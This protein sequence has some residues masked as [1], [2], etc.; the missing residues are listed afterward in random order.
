MTPCSLGDLFAP[1][2]VPDVA[3]KDITTDSR[4]IR[5]GSL[6]LACAGRRRHGLEFAAQAVA[7][8]A[9]A[10]AWE[11]A[12]G[13]SP[14]QLPAHVAGFEV[15]GLSAAVGQ[16]ADR[17][18]AEPS[19][20]LDVTGVTGTNG[21]TTTAW[22]ISQAFDQLGCRAAY[23][24]TMGYGLGT[25]L[26]PSALT[27]PGVIAVHR[28]LREMAD[29]GATAVVMEVSSH[30]LDQGRVDA[31][32]IRTAAF[33]NLS[34]DHLDYH[35]TMEAY[36]AAKAKLFSMDSV[37]TAVI[38]TG[39][40]FGADLVNLCGR[41]TQVIDVALRATGDQAPGAALEARMVESSRAGLILQFTGK[42]GTAVLKSPLWGRFNAENLLVATG[43]LLAHG[44]GLEAAT[45]A[46]SA[47]AAPPGR[48]QVLR[49]APDKPLVIVD[50]AHTPDALRQALGVIREHSWGALTVVFGCGGERDQGKRGE[51]G[52][53]ARRLAN[54][55]IVTDDNPR[56]DVPGEI[57][58]AILAGIGSGADVQVEHDRA[59]AIRMA[60][61]AAGPD[62][63]VLIAGKGSENYQIHADTSVPFSDAAVAAAV[64]GEHE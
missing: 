42:Y 45:E 55:I 32:R 26:Q 23:M 10:V 2:P 57:V 11:P 19:A 13:I 25:E 33:T 4:R 21:K 20:A 56:T 47:C 38:N 35:G 37:T 54:R 31:V 29:A 5:S 17:F 39:D 61:E 58:A 43:V 41:N 59:R 12:A 40:A 30:G 46:L 34:R 6:F 3:I 51:M 8:G 16:I 9:A 52:Q 44:Y 49:G 7:N 24:G 18:F 22:L 1:L 50:F 48:M 28:R 36:G 60:I 27:T 62:D 15:P 63:V 64:L 14:P 53:V